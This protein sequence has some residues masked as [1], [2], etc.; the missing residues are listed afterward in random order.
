MVVAHYDDEG[1]DDYLLLLL[2]AVTMKVLETAFLFCAFSTHNTSEF[3]PLAG[4]L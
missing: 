3:M 4:H 1:D 2:V